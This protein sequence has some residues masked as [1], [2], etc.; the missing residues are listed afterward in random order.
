MPGG[1]PLLLDNVVLLNELT[2]HF[3]QRI[4][5]LMLTFRAFS[6]HQRN[7][8]LCGSSTEEKSYAISGNMV[9]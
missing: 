4:K 1:L 2:M 8:G 7:F 6:F 3:G 9:T 5:F